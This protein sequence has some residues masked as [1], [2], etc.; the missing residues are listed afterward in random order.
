MNGIGEQT[1]RRRGF[2][3]RRLSRRRVPSRLT[4]WDSK[5]V[6]CAC[7]SCLM[8]SA[9]LRVVGRRSL[10]RLLL[11][12][13]AADSANA[14]PAPI[15]YKKQPA[16]GR[17]LILCEFKRLQTYSLVFAVMLYATFGLRTPCY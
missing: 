3:S 2:I 9:S 1:W 13:S 12:H 5:P 4:S 15:P 14:H 11:T 7:C 16:D 10:C 17:W 6:C 8:C